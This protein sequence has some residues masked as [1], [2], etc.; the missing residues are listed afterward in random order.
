MHQTNQA[1]PENANMNI[2][3]DLLMSNIANSPALKRLIEEVKNGSHVGGNYD[4]A[5]N[6]HN[7]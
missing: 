1:A 4:R 7:R 6:R 5:H 3:A 2:P